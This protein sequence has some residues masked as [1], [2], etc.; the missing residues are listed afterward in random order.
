[1]PATSYAAAPVKKVAKPTTTFEVGGRV[2][3]ALRQTNTKAA[4]SIKPPV[5]STADGT[6]VFQD[7]STDSL[8]DMGHVYPGTGFYMSGSTTNAGITFGGLITVGN[9]TISYPTQFGPF[10]AV[11]YNTN[12]GSRAIVD[13]G[14]NGLPLLNGVEWNSW[15]RDRLVLSTADVY[16][17]TSGFTI[18]AG[19]GKTMSGSSTKASLSPV[20]TSALENFATVELYNKTGGTALPSAAI[21]KEVLHQFSLGFLQDLAPRFGIRY[22]MNG[23]TVGADYVGQTS[24]RPGVVAVGKSL[25]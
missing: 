1:M 10:S 23:F 17:N 7:I 9:F 15:D 5:G 13:A 21:N 11:N 20:S 16:M 22:E 6:H 8:L 24:Q 19:Y 3:Y 14:Y 2:G 4:S 18:V 12:L 25:G